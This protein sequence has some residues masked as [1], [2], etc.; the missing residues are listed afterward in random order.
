[1][2]N[3]LFLS[4]FFIS[5]SSFAQQ[6][7]PVYKL[8]AVASPDVLIPNAEFAETH[9]TGF[10]A[11]L[12]IGYKINNYFAPTVSYHY[13]SV[14]AKSNSFTD[15]TASSIKA[16]SRIYLGNFYLLGDAGIIITNGYDNATRF[17]YGIGGGD[18][19]K[20][21]HRSRLDISAAYEGFNTGRN[22][23]IIA[24]RLGYNYLI[25]R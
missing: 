18:E 1:M 4:L 2:R 22:N 25:G 15:L 13:Y 3:F 21:N 14:P 24:V 16:G 19:I 10:G 17:I 8:F 20:L 7:K 11:S 9:K 6:N 23:G 12:A 5:V